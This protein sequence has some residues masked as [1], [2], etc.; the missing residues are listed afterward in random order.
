MDQTVLLE[1]LVQ[2]NNKSR[3]KLK[4]G[5]DIKRDTFDSVSALYGSWELTLNVFRSGSFPIKEK[6]GKGLKILTK[7]MIQRFPIALAEVKARDTS[8]NL[9]NEI[10]QIIYS[11]YRV[12]ETT[13]NVYDNIMNSIK[14]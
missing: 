13:K 1:N 5:K 10:K 12:K 8:E 14:V 7:Q 4:E 3:P 11:L 6:K 9:L 2:S